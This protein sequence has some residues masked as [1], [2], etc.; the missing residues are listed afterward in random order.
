MDG[1]VGIVTGGGSGI[2]RA[3]AEALAARGM[4]VV[5][6]SRRRE[7]LER[8]A[9]EIPGEVWPYAVDLR[10]LGGVQGLVRDTVNRYGRLDLVI[11]NSG[12]AIAERLDQISDEHWN[13]VMDT[14]LRGAFWLLREAMPHFR[15]QGRGDVVNISS[16]A[17]L[18]GYSNVSSYCAS[19]FGILGLGE[20]LRN[21]AKEDGLDVRVFNF[22]PGMVD[23]DNTGADQQ[24]RGGAIHVRNMVKLL[25]FALDLDRDVILDD[26]GIFAR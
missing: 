7:M 14:N 5:I 23:V 2:G 4:K 19:K 10:D 1:Q 12:L 20:A 24:P 3:M 21:E 18:H 8:V 9:Q 11:N 17:G 26:L 15:K 16:Q 13:T 25:M 6:A 22:C